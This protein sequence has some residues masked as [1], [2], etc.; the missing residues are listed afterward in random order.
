M[1]SAGGTI[2]ERILALLAEAGPPLNDDQ[3]ATLI[4]VVRQQVNDRCRQLAR[5]GLIVR[6]RDSDGKIV[7]RR[8]PSSALPL[9]PPASPAT[10]VVARRAD[11]PSDWFWESHV[12]ARLR[13][14][15]VAQGWR[16][17]RES[18]CLSRERGIDLLLERHGPQL[19]IEV[20]GF[21]STTYR[22]G[23][24]RG[25][26]KP[27][28]PT[29]QAKHWFAEVLLAAIRIQSKHPEYAVA[30]AFPRYA[31]VPK[32]DRVHQTC[33]E[34]PRHRSVPSARRRRHRRGAGAQRAHER[35]SCMSAFG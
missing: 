8:A 24:L 22:R 17:L 34:A 21:P 6:G 3:I 32:P 27:T 10:G 28:Q 14:H 11:E 29:L 30:V 2:K 33:S 20:K 13:D 12:Q 26:P 9:K 16:V 35:R 1:A 4:G 25:Q 7:N 5:S 23:P 19:A 31:A 15:F 18:D